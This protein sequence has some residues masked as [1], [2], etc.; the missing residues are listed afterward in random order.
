MKSKIQNN[1][2]NGY[3]INHDTEIFMI[4]FIIRVS[5]ICMLFECCHITKNDYL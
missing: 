5:D 4:C 3:L 1:F 2:A